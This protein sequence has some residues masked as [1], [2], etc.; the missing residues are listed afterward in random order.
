MGSE[1]ITEIA[2]YVSKSM[3]HYYEEAKCMYSSEEERILGRR[4]GGSY[5]FYSKVMQSEIKTLIELEMKI[6]S[7]EIIF[8]DIRYGKITIPDGKEE[9]YLDIF[10]RELVGRVTHQSSNIDSHGKDE[11]DGLVNVE[12]LRAL[13]IVLYLFDTSIKSIKNQ[14]AARNN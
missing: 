5:N 7:F 6:H 13:S 9:E 11:L 3:Q 10:R 1:N 4:T 2:S 8:P 12:R 14:I